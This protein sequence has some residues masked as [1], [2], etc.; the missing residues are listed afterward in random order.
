MKLTPENEDDK[1]LPDE[2]KDKLARAVAHAAGQLG[3][4]KANTLPGDPKMHVLAEL[5]NDVAQYMAWLSRQTPRAKGSLDDMD[6][7]MIREA[8]GQ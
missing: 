7:Q 2:V 4:S 5:A 6:D 1:L 8:H 3:M